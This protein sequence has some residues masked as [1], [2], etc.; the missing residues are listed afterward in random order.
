LEEDL[1]F[2]K[3]TLGREVN[4]HKQAAESAK[5]NAAKDNQELLSMRDELARLAKEADVARIEHEYMKQRAQKDRPVNRKKQTLGLCR[6]FSIG[7]KP[8]D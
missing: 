5:I 3:E 1:R 2:T 6:A 7:I 8:G 4:E